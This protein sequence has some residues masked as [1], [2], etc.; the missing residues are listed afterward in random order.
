[1]ICPDCHLT[2]KWVQSRFFCMKCEI[3]YTPADSRFTRK[4]NLLC[5]VRAFLKKEPVPFATIGKFEETPEPEIDRL[6]QHLALASR[7][8]QAFVSVAA[9]DLRKALVY[10]IRHGLSKDVLPTPVVDWWITRK[11]V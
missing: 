3:E 2:M 7:Q 6:V 5:E 4:K 9:S 11:D 1:M 10:I 8:D